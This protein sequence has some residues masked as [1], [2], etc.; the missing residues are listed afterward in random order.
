[1]SLISLGYSDSQFAEVNYS[2]F[3][4]GLQYGVLDFNYDNYNYAGYGN[5]FD[6]SL[7][8]TMQSYL[9]YNFLKYWSLELGYQYYGNPCFE[10]KTEKQYMLQQGGHLVGKVNLLLA[11]NFSIYAKSGVGLVF[12]SSLESRDGK[13]SSQSPDCHLVPIV[14]GGVCYWVSKE[15]GFDLSFAST[16]K[17]NDLPSMQ[18]YAVGFIY[19]F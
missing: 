8:F 16:W 12:R 1:M 11:N 4:I 2:G 7:H 19:R 15:L 10:N 5:K 14:G 18:T 3:Y 13:F 6:E 17:V 9:G